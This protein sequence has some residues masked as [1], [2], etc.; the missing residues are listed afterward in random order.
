MQ[1]LLEMADENISLLLKRL[2]D[3]RLFETMLKPPSKDL[4]GSSP[5]W[6]L[7]LYLLKQF[8]QSTDDLLDIILF[9]MT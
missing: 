9:F 5:L 1:V 8:C 7:K 6:K 2:C 3:T 4:G